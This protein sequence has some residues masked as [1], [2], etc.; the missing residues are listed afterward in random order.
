MSIESGVTF[1]WNRYVDN[2]IMIG[3][4]EDT[5]IGSQEEIYNQIG[6]AK[7]DLLNKALNLLKTRK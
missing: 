3:I 4:D 6:F 5:P 7:K 2:G 1:G